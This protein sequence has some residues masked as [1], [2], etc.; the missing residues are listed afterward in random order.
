M[1]ILPKP[2]RS[3]AS[4]PEFSDFR[5]IYSAYIA[6]PVPEGAVQLVLPYVSKHSVVVEIGA[7]H[8][9]GTAA[10]SRRARHVYAF[11]PNPDSFRILQHVAGRI[12]NVTLSRTAVSS[13]KEVAYLNLVEA[14][15]S[16][17]A[18]STRRLAGTKYRGILRV[19]AQDLDSMQLAL[20]PTIMVVDCEGAEEDALAG[21]ARLLPGLSGLFVET[22][23][24]ADGKNT[25][26][27]V[28]DLVRRSFER[29]GVA[30]T[31][32]DSSWVI[33]LRKGIDQPRGEDP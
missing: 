10:Y 28:L 31:A 15:R 13:V 4:R 14:E 33:G 25:L 8:G 32:N 16:S 11:E 30:S 12:P 23:T 7:G 21:A 19:G 24:L 18:T 5:Y 3:L 2:L 22:H 20:A 26:A 29:V 9:G 1:L 6:R 27:G 17:L